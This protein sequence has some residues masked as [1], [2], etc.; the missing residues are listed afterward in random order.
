VEQQVLDG[1]DADARE[2]LAERRPDAAQARD[3]TLG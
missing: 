3:R 2:R 1:A